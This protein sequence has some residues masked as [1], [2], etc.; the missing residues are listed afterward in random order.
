MFFLETYLL[1]LEERK[2]V[3]MKNLGYYNGAYGAIEEMT[4][5]MNDRVHFFG[6]GR[7]HPQ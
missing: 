7:I 6:D 1:L 2:D 4:V 5:P 3:C